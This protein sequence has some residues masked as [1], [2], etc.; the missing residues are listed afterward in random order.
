MNFFRLFQNVILRHLRYE[1]GKLLLAIVGVAIGVAVFVS[2]RLANTTAFEAFTTSLDVVTGKANLQVLSNDGLGFDERFIAQLRRSPAVIGA[3]PAIEQY[4]QVEDSLELA[5]PG[6]GMPLLVFGIDVFAENAFRTYEFQES[7]GGGDVGLQFLLQRNAII[8]TDKLA[9]Q[10]RLQRGDSIRLIANGSRIAFQVMGIVKP[11]GTASALGGNFALLDIASAQEVFGRIGRLDRIDLLVPSEEREQLSEYLAETAPPGVVVREPQ[12][13]GSQATR[14]LESFD[15]NLTALAFIALFVSMFII[16]NTMLTNTLRR[17]RELGILRALG[18]TRTTIVALFLGEAT[19][20]GL[21]GVAVGLPVGIV[22]ARLA[23]DQVTR[24]ITTLYILTVTDELMIDPATLVLGGVIGLLA[25]VIS[26]LPAALEG[27]RAHPRETFS[28]QTFETKVS[29]NLKRI[30]TGTALALIAAYAAS[31]LGDMLMSPEL[32]FVSAGLLLLGVA[33]LTPAV[34]SGAGR[35]FGRLIRRLFGVEGELANAYLLASLGRSS[36][37]IAALMTA[38]AMLIGVSTM[39]DS[40][41]RTVEYWMRQTVTADLYITVASNRLSASAVTPIPEPVWRYVDTL[42]GVRIIDALRRLKVGYQ[43][44]SIF[45]SGATF[46]APESEAPL[47]FQEGGKWNDIMA[48][49]DSGAVV[50]SEGFG[51]RYGKGMSDT[52]T[53][54]TP[55]GTQSLKIAGI[56]Y[57]YSSDAGSVMLKRE[58]FMRLFADSALNSIAIH[59]RDTSA[60]EQVRQNIERSFAGRYSLVV[61]SNRALRDDALE[62]FDQ[63]FAITYALQL[64]AVIVAAIGVANTLA[65]LVVER[66]REIGILKAVGATAGQIRKMTLVQAGLIGA[67]SQ[68]LGVGAG[69]LLSMIL[70]Y[71]INRVSFGWTI[72]LTIS[73]EILVLSGL[74]VI[75]TAFIAGLVPANAAARKPVADVVKAE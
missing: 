36:T 46:N 30:F 22:L 75:V 24:T 51:L 19:L 44:G 43:D 17:R 11:E 29:L 9:R 71:V 6:S 60:M 63:T 14:M 39:V 41:R 18:A 15:L 68:F 10:Y 42:Q 53:I 74:L 52:I 70:I 20:I 8:I 12:S 54:A 16:Y 23:L 67:A 59:L 69:L 38:I 55:T 66:S 25:S 1:W 58:P 73:P 5:R 72:Q 49:L 33:L 3:A 37:A 27:A 31:F 21:L 40:F 61:Y 50:V 26:A 47:A 4:A 13:R 57:D 62:I 34:I 2:I 28:V 65:A 64:V 56:F 35:L 7:A 48:A 45:V 32:G